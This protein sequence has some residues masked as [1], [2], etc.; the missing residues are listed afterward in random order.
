MSQ[1][2]TAPASGTQRTAERLFTGIQP[3][4]A[5]H[6]GNYL[7]AQLNYVAL[8]DRYESIYG[9]VDY[10][11]LT[12]V[13]DGATLRSLTHEMML[14][15]LAV[16]LD[17]T[18]CAIVRQSDLP[19]HAE[20]CW[21]FDTVV[22]VSWLERNPTYKAALAEGKENSAGLL[23]Y[24]VLQ[25]ADIVIYKATVVP[26]GKDQDAHLELSREIV[27]AFNRRYGEIFPEPQAAYTDAPVVLGTDGARKMGKSA[28]N[29]I[30]IFAEPDEIR[31]LVMSMVTDPQRIKRTDPGRPEVC[32]VCQL[33][34]F[35]GGD[36]LEIQ[37]GERT[38]RTG[39]VETKGLL[40]E[41]IIEHFRPMRERRAALAADGGIVEETL[42][43]GRD[44]VRPILE[45]TMA[46]VRAAV[47]IGP[48]REI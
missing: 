35:F 15:L 26:V 22:P 25:A 13:H 7:G 14:D 41:R 39:C 8:Q 3:S 48:R 18:K 43:A 32:N 12:T 42:A 31:R 21:I 27:R 28:G 19:E 6:L 24:P 36:Y 23:N 5:S 2:L 47:G 46:E 29:T 1:S 17:P 38:A 44:R 37:D 4:G 11:A 33:H 45:A 10:H 20:L 34:R 9:I 16:G 30:P 40:A